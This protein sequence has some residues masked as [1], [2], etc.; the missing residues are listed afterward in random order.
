MLRHGE[1]VILMLS[2]LL[3][4]IAAIT[5]ATFGISIFQLSNFIYNAQLFTVS[6]LMI[7]SFQILIELVRERPKSPVQ[8]VRTMFGA[9]YWSRVRHGLPIVIG[10]VLFMP[11]FSAMKSAIPLLN[12]F[13]WDSTFIEL[14]RTIHGTDPWRF[15]Q[16]LFGSPLIT[17]AIAALYHLWI[18]LIY[19]GS[20]YFAFYVV[21]RQLVYRY[22]L[23]YLAIW[24][25][26]GV[27]LAIIFASVGPCFVGPLLGMDTFDEKMALLTA[28][29]EQFPIMVLD[30][31]KLLLAWY[32]ADDYGLGRGITAMPSMHVAL[33][34]L[35]F[36]AIRKVNR[37]AGIAFFIF[38]VAVLLG[39]VHTAYHY[40]VDGYFSIILTLL[41]WKLAGYLV[42]QRTK[43]SQLVTAPA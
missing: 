15:L 19:C 6:W 18:L 7:V 26:G 9:S 10:L 31:Q 3:T 4:A 42:S 20:I 32:M 25:I 21:E 41:V 38:F 17:A 36:L 30:V 13:T 14:D 33:A 35:F 34:F 22:F 24:S 8:H 39:S 40:A 28:A 1:I 29:N 23:S 27:V 16:P 43:E 12:D 37:V 5:L 11:A 2:I